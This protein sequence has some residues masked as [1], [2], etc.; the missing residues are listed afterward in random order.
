[1]NE[2]SKYKNECAGMNK[3]LLGN[4]D[5]KDINMLNNILRYEQQN[6]LAGILGQWALNLE[7]ASLEALTPHSRMKPKLSKYGTKWSALYGDN[8]QEGVC[9]FGDT[10]EQAMIQFD[11]EWLNAP[12]R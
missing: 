9:G 7:K 6:E 12:P 3:I 8:I 10:P 11:I 2:S 1:V 4:G 5:L